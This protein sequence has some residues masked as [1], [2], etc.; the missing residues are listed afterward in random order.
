LAHLVEHVTDPHEL[1]GS[2]RRRV[3]DELKKDPHHESPWK[4]AGNGWRT[5]LT[6]RL[7]QLQEV[8]NR[9]LNTPRSQN[10]DELF[11][12]ALGL[13]DI[14]V[15]WYWAGISAEQARAKLDRFIELRGDIAHRGG[16]IVHR[17]RVVEFL[18]H[19][20]RLVGK[21]DASVDAFVHDACGT[22]L[23]S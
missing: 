19:A 21:T 13:P 5:L 18:N 2:L 4:L 6:D 12:D 1:P 7:E 3:A 10:I 17:T 16:T 20:K 8:R 22:W 11:A 14:S 9:G 23:F 15:A